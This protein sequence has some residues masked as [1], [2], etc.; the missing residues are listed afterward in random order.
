MLGRNIKRAR[1]GAWLAEEAQC[2][3]R[4]QVLLHCAAWWRVSISERYV[5]ESSAKL[6]LSDD[7][8]GSESARP[9]DLS[10]R[11][12]DVPWGDG[13]FRSLWL[14]IE[15][16]HGSLGSSR[17]KKFTLWFSCT[18]SC[19]ASGASCVS[20]SYHTVPDHLSSCV[21]VLLSHSCYEA[22]RAQALKSSLP[23]RV[24]CAVALSEGGWSYCL[25]SVSCYRILMVN[26]CVTFNR[27]G[28]GAHECNWRS[29]TCCS[30]MDRAGW[31]L[32][33]SAD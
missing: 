6:L 20:A 17:R 11:R 32:H 8:L 12:A 14:P 27:V 5:A 15:E 33:L 23:S 18:R 22:L 2:R 10:C 3:K 25:S 28:V 9:L 16:L 29:C 21:F 26:M 31:H 7:V 30:Q 13:D 1:R 4:E 19:R 24:C